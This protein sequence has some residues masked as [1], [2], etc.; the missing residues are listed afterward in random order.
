MSES[1]NDTLRIDVEPVNKAEQ[2][3]LYA[4]RV[5]IHPKLVHGLFRQAKWLVMAVTLTIYYVTPWIRWDRGD[6][7]PNQAVLIDFPSRRFYFFNLEIWPQE[8]YFVT[9]LMVLAAL[10]LFLVTSVAG[11]VWCGYACPQTVWTDLFIHIERMI[12]GD[13]N[14]RLRLDKAPWTASKIAKKFLKHTIWILIAIATGGA[15]VFYFDNAP[16]LAADLINFQADFIAYLSIG[17][18]TFTTY[19]LGGLAR[20]QVCTYMCPW[21]RIQGAMFDEHTYAVSYREDRGEPRGAHK[22]DESWEG[23]GDCIDCNQ[24]VAACPVGIDIR[25]GLQFECIQCALC[26]D[27]CNAIMK[28]V[29]RPTGLIAYDSLDNQRLR[30]TGEGQKTKIIR[31][32]TII[33]ASVIAIVG[34]VMLVALI[35]RSELEVNV[36]RDRNPLFVALSDGSVRNG[37][38]FKLLNKAHHQATYRISA[39]GVEGAQLKLRGSDYS[40]M[41]EVTAA[42]DELTAYK[43]FVTVPRTALAHPDLS[44]GRATLR[45]DVEEVGGAVR[46]TETTSF[47]GP[48]R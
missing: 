12:E 34:I 21:P 23:R 18:F 10:V 25:D 7:A 11:R 19:T 32:R 2:R 35:G 8:F 3:P 15:W 38:E 20:E 47:H 37:Y 33:Y 5:K 43:V 44:D 46:V 14:K 28:K 22:K 31:P 39:T 9:G 36:I 30:T 45:F 27:A 40:D 26:I 29:D 24:C 13:R 48:K 17:V 42:P 6:L 41:L 4:K 1:V 16:E